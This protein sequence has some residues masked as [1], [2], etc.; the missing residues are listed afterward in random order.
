MKTQLLTE[1]STKNFKLTE[2]ERKFIKTFLS[3][4]DCCAQT[5]SELLDDNFSCKCLEDFEDMYPELSKNQ[6]GG[7]LSSL[8]EKGVIYLEE[9][10]GARA[11]ST[12]IWF[13]EPDLYW[14][15]DLYL[16]TLPKNIRF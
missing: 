8:Q 16:E 5:P 4:N 9:R 1:Y 7:Y 3:E 11:T 6:I 10:M 14:V 2:G 15:N 12:N 13:F